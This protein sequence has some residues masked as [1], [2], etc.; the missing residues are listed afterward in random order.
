[1]R[2][3]NDGSLT[4]DRINQYFGW[5]AD[6]KNCAKFY[7]STLPTETT[8]KLA[9]FMDKFN[10]PTGTEDID[11]CKEKKFEEFIRVYLLK[12]DPAPKTNPNSVRSVLAKKRSQKLKKKLY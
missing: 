12:G 3:N 9:C 10:Y 4:T 1:M 2:N 8:L 6:A 11:S 5:G 7:D